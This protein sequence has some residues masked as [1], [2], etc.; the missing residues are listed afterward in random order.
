MASQ[1]SRTQDSPEAGWPFTLRQPNQGESFI[2]PVLP[3]D[4]A[5]NQPQIV[6]LAGSVT[7][8]RNDTDRELAFRQVGKLSGLTDFHP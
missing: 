1:G 7:P 6:V 2:V 4:L 3:Q 5:G 8:Y